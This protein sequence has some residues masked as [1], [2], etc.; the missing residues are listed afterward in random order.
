[1]ETERQ[2]Q[3]QLYLESDHWKEL[4]KIVLDRDGNKCTRCDSK[5]W[6]QAHHKIYRKR[7]EDSVPGDLV[8]LCR[9][10]HEK[11]HGLKHGSKP[12]PNTL[13]VV[14]TEGA[15]WDWYRL[16]LARSKRQ[17]SRYQFKIIRDKLLGNGNHPRA[18]WR[19][20]KKKRKWKYPKRSFSCERAYH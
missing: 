19:S 13:P 12:K 8:T 20:K 1:M 3:Y 9:S 14:A 15:E 5:F 2:L 11:E 6:L 17:I 10:C 4:R 16:H 7:F 18:M